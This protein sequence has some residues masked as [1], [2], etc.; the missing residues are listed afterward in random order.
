MSLPHYTVGV[1]MNL[2]KTHL[3]MFW[4]HQKLA[5][6][7]K[8]NL[9]GTGDSLQCVI[10]MQIYGHKGARLLTCTASQALH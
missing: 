4:Q 7:F 10:Y 3:Q 9:T 5:F 2:F 6:H 8:A 1:H